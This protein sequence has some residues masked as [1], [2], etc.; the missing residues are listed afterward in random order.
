MNSCFESTVRVCSF[1]MSL[2]FGFTMVVLAIT[3]IILISKNDL[4]SKDD[5]NDDHDYLHNLW[6]QLMIVASVASFP[7][8]IFGTIALS[9]QV[10]KKSNGESQPLLQKGFADISI[11]S[12]C[13]LFLTLFLASLA[14][15]GILWG[16]AIAYYNSQKAV[17]NVVLYIIV[18]ILV[19]VISPILLVTSA[20]VFSVFLE[21]ITKGS[22]KAREIITKVLS[23]V[24]LEENNG[25]HIWK[26]LG[27]FCFDVN[28]QDIKPEKERCLYYCSCTL[29]TWILNAIVSLAFVLGV[30]F[31]L[32][33]T[34]MEQ[35]TLYSCPHSSME[36]DCFNTMDFHYVDCSD[37]EIANM[38]F[39]LLHCFRFFRFGR[40]S[41]AI[42]AI[43]DSFAFYL[44]MLAIFTIAFY[45]AK[46][47]NIFKRKI[48]WGGIGCLLVFVVVLSAGVVNFILTF[49][50]IQTFQ[51]IVLA[52]YIL[53]IGILICLS[54]PPLP[55]PRTD[56]TSVNS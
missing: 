13:G 22:L 5:S 30:S 20:G 12:F 29:A 38:T 46:V 17:K 41:Y 16:I 42:K 4:H 21:Y 25:R 8:S 27:W 37:P 24:K 3:S 32:S 44:A 18:H 53:M 33:A 48:P 28:E 40:D 43:A 14:L 36:V 52:F 1:V 9:L 35:T 2:L 47:P 10:K 49:E 54:T 7:Y 56:G 51:I 45:A 19:S 15:L 6:F 55:R 11:E 39:N 31:F 34:I 23:V 50:F 26:I